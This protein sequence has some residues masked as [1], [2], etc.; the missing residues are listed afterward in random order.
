MESIYI[1]HDYL[2]IASSYAENIYER[3][4]KRENIE[5][6]DLKVLFHWIW[7]HVVDN[8]NWVDID[9]DFFMYDWKGIKY[10][11]IWKLNKFSMKQHGKEINKWDI[12]DM[13]NSSLLSKHPSDNYYCINY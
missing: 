7:A 8:F 6:S 11:D 9:F 13:I 10:F 2:D 3:Y 12:Y 4:L 1:I 5:E